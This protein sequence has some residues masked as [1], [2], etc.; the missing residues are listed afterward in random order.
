[1]EIV[2]EQI[3]KAISDLKD[4]DDIKGDTA[5]MLRKFRNAKI[6]EIVGFCT[7]HKFE[8]ARQC[9]NRF[10]NAYLP[11]EAEK[12]RQHLLSEINDYEKMLT[13]EYYELEGNRGRVGFAPKVVRKKT[14]PSSRKLKK[15]P[16]RK[17]KRH[18][19]KR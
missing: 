18:K 10:D 13:G 6:D 2:L 1:M 4:G 16:K 7:N 14:K 9:A 3:E 15:A 5:Y 8:E 17:K 19:G 12:A 11:D